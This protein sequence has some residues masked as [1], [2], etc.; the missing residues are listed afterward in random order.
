MLGR[1]RGSSPER[2]PVGAVAGRLD[3]GALKARLDQLGP[4]GEVAARLD[5]AAEQQLASLR[6]LSQLTTP[7][8]LAYLERIGGPLAALEPD[9]GVYVVSRGYAA[10]LAVEADPAAYGAADIPVL[11]SLPALRHGRPPGDL[12]N[13]LVRATRRGFDRIRAVSVEVWEGYVAATTNRVHRR[14]P[15][16]DPPE[17][18]AG[19]HLDPAVVDGLLRFGWVLR[20]A[21]LHYGLAFERE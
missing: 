7:L 8:S 5:A 3:Q 20:Q 19:G 10:H 18:A 21:D 16:A 11:G 4:D 6:S 17:G 2:L 9:I 1:R 15:A 14:E 12:L 13:R